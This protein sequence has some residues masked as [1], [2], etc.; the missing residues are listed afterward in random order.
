VNS[1]CPQ[2]SSAGVRSPVPGLAI[3]CPG[4]ITNEKLDILRN[5]DAVYI[6]QIRKAGLYGQI[7]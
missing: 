5:A 1:A 4:D 2:S 3:R 7:W 6:D